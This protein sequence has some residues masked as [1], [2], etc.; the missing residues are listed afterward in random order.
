MIRKRALKCCLLIILNIILMAFFVHVK[1]LAYTQNAINS[2]N[3]SKI[4]ISSVENYT[5]P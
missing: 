5:I 1:D 4:N 3:E 2:S